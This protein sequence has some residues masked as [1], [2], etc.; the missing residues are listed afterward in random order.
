[1]LKLAREELKRHD[2]ENALVYIHSALEQEPKSAEGHRLREEV[3]RRYVAN[4]YQNGLS[5]NSVL[6]LLG[7]LE[8]LANERL[9][10]QEGF[11]LSRI[12]GEMDISG[13]LSVCP[14]READSLRMIKTM[15]DRGIIGVE[16][17]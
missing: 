6:K 8:Q 3:E 4:V 13:I 7:S 17:T 9:G 14:F 10:P 12:N 11:V 1:L 16:K 5:P 15:L 2:V